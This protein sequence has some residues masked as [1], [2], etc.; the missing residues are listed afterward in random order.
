MKQPKKPSAERLTAL[1][2]RDYRSYLNSNHW[3]TFRNRIIK[4]LNVCRCYPV[5]A[6]VVAGGLRAA[7][8]ERAASAKG[9]PANGKEEET[10]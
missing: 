1:G 10:R 9:K 3:K 7:V 6:A 2:Y 4:N 8:C 5:I